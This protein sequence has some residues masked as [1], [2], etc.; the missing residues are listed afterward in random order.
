M[1]VFWSNGSTHYNSVLADSCA[2]NLLMTDDMP[3]MFVGC[4]IY[5]IRGDVFAAHAIHL[6]NPRTE[7][8]P[9]HLKDSSSALA[10]GSCRLIE[11]LGVPSLSRV[12]VWSASGKLPGTARQFFPT[13]PTRLLAPR[14]R[15]S[16]LAF[17]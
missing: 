1:K 9:L 12:L 16:A 7:L 6:L 8:L 13:S 11:D 10:Y 15:P 5:N 2:S 4:S 14:L 17:H 3:S